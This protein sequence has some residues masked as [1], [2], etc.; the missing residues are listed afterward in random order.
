MKWWK[1]FNT[2]HL[3]MY[4]FEFQP[5]H[6]IFN[7]FYWSNKYNLNSNLVLGLI[8]QTSIFTSST[9]YFTSIWQCVIFCSP[10]GRASGCAKGKGGS[11]HMYTK[12]FYGGN[13]IVGAQ[14]CFM[15]PLSYSILST[16]YY[17]IYMYV[18]TDW[19]IIKFM[20]PVIKKKSGQIND[21]EK[22]Y[23]LNSL[24]SSFFLSF[25]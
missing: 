23:L 24:T 22:Q 20:F 14:V 9:L 10:L 18:D 21:V 25:F 3:L 17:N 16:E 2:F 12:N 11:M 5:D 19:C 1:H 8:I 4:I 15:L 7:W 13:G 6:C